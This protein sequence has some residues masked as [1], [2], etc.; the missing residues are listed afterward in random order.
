MVSDGNEPGANSSELTEKS[1]GV[2]TYRENGYVGQA[3]HRGLLVD[4]V[5]LLRAIAKRYV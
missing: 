5:L 1:S 4:A 3:K 2:D